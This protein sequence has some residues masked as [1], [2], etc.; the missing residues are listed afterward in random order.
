MT[1][2][3]T[4][5]APIGTVM[6]VGCAT[7]LTVCAIA[8]GASNKPANARHDKVVFRS[9]SKAGSADLDRA[10]FPVGLIRT[11]FGLFIA[12]SFFGFSVWGGFESPRF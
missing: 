12:S 2:F 4:A 3:E 7:V 10:I 9:N 5:I 6:R 1:P 11:G 8:A